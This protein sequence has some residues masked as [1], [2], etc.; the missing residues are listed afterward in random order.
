MKLQTRLLVSFV[1]CGLLPLAIA[2]LVSTRNTSSSMQRIEADAISDLELKAADQLGALRDTKREQIEKY[3]E[4]I[5]DQIVTFSENKMV[6]DAMGQ[7]PKLFN[8]YRSDLNDELS[9]EDKKE[10]L[11]TYYEQEFSSEYR[12]QN[13]GESP[14]IE[15]AFN[16]LDED[17]VALQH[18]F[19]KANTNPLGSKHLLDQAD[20]TPYSQ[21]HA[22]VH[23][24]VRSYLERFGYYDIFLVDSTTGDIVY[25]VFKE[26]DFSTSLLTGPYAST[27]FGEAFRQANAAK[28]PNEYFLVDFK[29]YA[30]SYE[31]PAS[32]ISSPIFDGDKKI[33][34]AIFQMPIDKINDLMAFRRGMG[35][36]GETYLVGQDNLLRCDTFRD[37]ENRS[38]I[39]SFRSPEKGKVDTE[40]V[41]RALLGE[42]G[43]AEVSNYL[44]E[45]VVSAYCPANF[46]GIRYALIAEIT[47]DEAYA[48]A[49]Q[50]RQVA[51]ESF[52]NLL[53]WNLALA[54]IASLAVAL[55]AIFVASRIV[56]PLR[57]NVEMLKDIAEGD[58]DLS[59]RLDASRKDE[60]GE[61]ANWF[62]TFVEKLQTIINELT[63]NSQTLNSSSTELSD[64]AGQ[65]ANGAND[66]TKQSGTVA[67]AA[68]E[69]AVNMSSMASS[70]SEVS[71][72]VKNV[73]HSID[74]MTRSINEVAQN[75]EKSASVAGQAAEL[76][77]L[78]NEK[79]GDLGGAADE[80]GKVIEVIQDI[81]EQTNLLAL[82]ATI[83]AARA[84]EAGKGFAVVATEV[85]E[86]AK[87]TASATEDIRVRIEGIQRSTGEA[88]EAIGEISNVINNVNQ[89]S[90]TIAS[91]V[92][93]QSITTQQ[94]ANN[95][96]Q[97]ASAAELVASG[98]SES[99]TASQEI[100]ESIAKVDSVLQQTANGAQQSRE[101]GCEFSQLANEM[102]SLISQ[103]KTEKKA[104]VT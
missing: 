91:A 55:V 90:R 69:M 100:T 30:P 25:S 65:L 73:A 81:A 49:G 8:D 20:N 59:K 56:K 31:A 52:W 48:S 21:L 50:I 27:N 46:L 3:F 60:L 40:S 33:G 5:R 47:S 4:T 86:L 98:V 88:V 96:S 41:Q 68:E 22:E 79:I 1:I 45:Q 101:A 75:A 87:Q 51:N 24:V 53:G 54:V 23:P 34:V 9:I 7:F 38:I 85:K 15:A 62:N 64:V 76:V 14:D 42:T 19:I 6:V 93:E 94:I 66:A 92:E 12:S 104:I 36:T 78:S 43:V 72:N 95:V 84:G 2:T 16:F 70:T 74:E 26:L 28:N 71:H 32:F 58:G 97:T 102:Q 35:E 61:L 11:L 39:S 89:V 13:N 80:I 82:N 17:S 10:E 44:G 99:A 18:S 63:R 103:F 83:E 67:A 57:T 77:S 29:Q 37:P